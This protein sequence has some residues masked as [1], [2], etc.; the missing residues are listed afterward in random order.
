MCVCS[1]EGLEAMALAIRNHLFSP[2][3]LWFWLVVLCVLCTLPY[4]CFQAHLLPHAC[5]KYVGRAYFLPCL[6]CTI[7]SNQKVFKGRWWAY[8]DEGT[9]PVAGGMSHSATLASSGRPTKG[10]PVL[11]GQ[12]PLFK[13]QLRELE[14]LGVSAIVNLC[15]E[16]MGP[17]DAYRKDGV[18]L[19][20]L[21]TVDHLEPTVPAMRTAVAFIE[22]H[23]KRGAGVY[24]HCKSGRGRSAAIAMAWLLQVKRMTPLQANQHLLAVRKVRAKLFLQKN[25][26]QFYEELP[27][28]GAGDAEQGGAQRDRRLSFATWAPNN[29]R[30]STTAQADVLRGG[31]MGAPA[32]V[33]PAAPTANGG[34]GGFMRGMSFRVGAA[35]QSAG[36]LLRGKPNTPR[37]DGFERASMAQYGYDAAPPDW[38]APQANGVWEI[39]VAP[40]PASIPENLPPWAQQQQQQFEEHYKTLPPPPKPPFGGGWGS[41]SSSFAKPGSVPYAPAFGGALPPAPPA[42]PASLGRQ[43]TFNDDGSRRPVF[44]TN[45]L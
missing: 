37:G 33:P 23:R 17:T 28:P 41:S 4:I 29:R 21:R 45:Q 11:L 22:H 32:N 5:G 18:S 2:F 38:D 40:I 44:M 10:P 19:L 16:F 34:V 14:T 3:G 26:I 35:A 27:P 1:D 42:P 39:P 25:V 12:A 36:G 15:D 7:R 6:P 9:T 8:V 30:N 31:G 43:G 20:W 24:I 13:S